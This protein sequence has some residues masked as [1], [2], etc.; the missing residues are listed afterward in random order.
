MPSSHLT[1]SLVPIFSRDDYSKACI[2]SFSVLSP[3]S[4]LFR[5][6]TLFPLLR[7]QMLIVGPSTPRKIV[8]AI[9]FVKRRDI[10]PL[11][12]NMAADKEEGSLY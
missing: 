3:F 2:G 11:V 1:V 7:N 8:G 5:I 6:T 10:V 12:S 9:S 4:L